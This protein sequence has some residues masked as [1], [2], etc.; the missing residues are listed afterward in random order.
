MRTIENPSSCATDRTSSLPQSIGSCPATSNDSAHGQDEDEGQE[1]NTSHQGH[2]ERRRRFRRQRPTAAFGNAHPN[3]E[4][5]EDAN[6]PKDQQQRAHEKDRPDIPVSYRDELSVLGVRPPLQKC[7]SEG[8]G[9]HNEQPQEESRDEPPGGHVPANGRLKHR[10]ANEAQSAADEERDKTDF[11]PAALV[12]CVEPH[13]DAEISIPPYRQSTFGG[14]SPGLGKHGFPPLLRSG[15]DRDG[16]Y[17]EDDTRRANQEERRLQQARSQHDDPAY[18][19]SN[20]PDHYRDDIVADLLSIRRNPRARSHAEA[21][22]PRSRL[23]LSAT[24]D[25]GAALP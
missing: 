17:E 21:P 12:E 19:P 7:H 22:M 18:R 10:E 6:E 14:T 1:G 11:Q 23:L 16:N 8:C 4:F 13:L 24:Q 3:R 2:Q 9:H 15:E 5:Q 25:V 20:R